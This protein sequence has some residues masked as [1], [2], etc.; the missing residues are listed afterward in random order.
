MTIILVQLAILLACIVTGT[1]RIG[2]YL[3]D[4][5]FMIPG[6]ANGSYR[7]PILASI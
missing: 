3:L 6:L 2:Q 4:R 7:G 1:T 5:S